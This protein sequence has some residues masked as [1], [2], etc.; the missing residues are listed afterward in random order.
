MA[1][2]LAL[3]AS[4]PAIADYE[5]GLNHLKNRNFSAA[6]REFTASSTEGDPRSMYQL[7]KLYLGGL[8]VKRDVNKATEYFDAAFD[9][10]QIQLNQTRLATAETAA[11]NRLAVELQAWIGQKVCRN[12]ILA[13]TYQPKACAV[14]GVC[15]YVNMRFDELAHD[16]QVFGNIEQMSS[17]GQ[18]VQVRIAG[19]ASD[20]MKRQESQMH[21]LANPVL[22]GEIEANDRNYLLIILQAAQILC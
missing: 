4:T 17:N 10:F 15:S 7:G 5:N 11:K 9:Q 1:W 19:W 2:A 12:G 22:D 21:L 8:G 20:S 6:I 14:G 13:Y 18:R 16:G 3:V